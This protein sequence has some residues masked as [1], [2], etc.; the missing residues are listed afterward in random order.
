MRDAY[1][2]WLRG[3]D[4]AA[5]L[6]QGPRHPQLP[7]KVERMICKALQGGY[8]L[9]RYAQRRVRVQLAAA[10][11]KPT[12]E[13]VTHAETGIRVHVVYFAHI[14]A[15]AN[16]DWE[17]LVSA[18]L[19]DVRDTGLAAAAATLDVVLQADGADA[20]ALLSRTSE[21]SLSL[22]PQAV[23]QIHRGNL[24]EYHGIR[25]ARSRA[26]AA[27]GDGT[28]SVIMY[29]HSK[30]M[31]HS[32]DADRNR[33]AKNL[34]ITRAVVLPWK[35][36]AARFA[37]EPRVRRAAYAV[38]PAGI[39]WYNFWWARAEVL[40]KR[41]EP[42]PSQDRFDH[43]CWLGLSTTEPAPGAVTKEW[44]YAGLKTWYTTDPHGSVS[45]CRK[46]WEAEVNTTTPADMMSKLCN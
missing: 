34:M 14:A 23:V 24:F 45:L 32:R 25:K 17:T 21:L 8:E 12:T 31:V 38:A 15:A 42:R 30:G 13:L 36:I 27:P 46:T 10:P 44:D 3:W 37:A 40:R 4:V 16:P 1:F 22:V 18:Q 29:H 20:G 6:N 35:R 9:Y 43:E 39:G 19:A 33:T 26:W 28:G 5:R 2:P 7:E 11:P 41:P